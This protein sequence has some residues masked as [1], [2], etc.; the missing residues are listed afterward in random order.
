MYAGVTKCYDPYYLLTG[1][2]VDSP[3]NDIFSKSSGK[4]Q[5]HQKDVMTA[6][7]IRNESGDVLLHNYYGLDAA[8][9]LIKLTEKFY[10]DKEKIFRTSRCVA[11]LMLKNMLLIFDENIEDQIENVRPV[12][13]STNKY[14]FVCHNIRVTNKKMRIIEQLLPILKEYVKTYDTDKWERGADEKRIKDIKK[15]L[16]DVE[17]ENNDLMRERKVR[18][19]DECG[20]CKLSCEVYE[21]INRSATA[22]HESFKKTLEQGRILLNL[23]EKFYCLFPERDLTGKVQHN[24]S[25]GVLEFLAKEIWGKEEKTPT[26]II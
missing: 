9:P 18:F 25:R 14:V 10:G 3:P 7:L 22:I 19:A 16:T 11:S 4:L 5:N 24:E 17:I 13:F 8:I 12:L 26:I 2:V 20:G 1:A 23:P 6:I 21:K 15:I